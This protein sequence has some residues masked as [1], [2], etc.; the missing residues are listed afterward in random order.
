MLVLPIFFS[1]LLLCA[2]DIKLNT[3]AASEIIRFSLFNY[4][5][6]I[7]DHYE[8]KTAYID[9]IVYLLNKHTGCPVEKLTA[10]FDSN[11]LNLEPNPVRYML[12]INK[13]VKAECGFYF[14]DT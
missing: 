4:D 6:L 10:I 3:I 12:I 13:E 11:T 8:K 1:P 5:N 2:A 9:Q 14:L 7:A